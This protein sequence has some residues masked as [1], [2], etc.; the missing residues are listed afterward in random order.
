MSFEKRTYVAGTIKITADNLNNIQDKIIELDNKS[1]TKDEVVE[2]LGFTPVEESSI[3]HKVSELENDSGYIVQHQ[4]LKT[5]N[6]ES[7]VGTGNITISGGSTDLSDYYTKDQIDAKGYLTEHQSLTDYA[8]KAWVEEKGYLTEHQSLSDYST[9]SEVQTMITNAINA[10][11]KFYSGT[12]TPSDSLGND[13]DLY[14][15]KED[16]GGGGGVA[17]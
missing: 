2:A 6:G 11:P 3:P 13:G 7:I 1:L 10:L 12:S 14:L 15:Q 9:T 5:I 17:D 4:S 16:S 8:T